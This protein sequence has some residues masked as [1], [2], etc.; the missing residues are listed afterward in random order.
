MAD[1][2]V[3][4]VREILK[5]SPEER[6]ELY[7]VSGQATKNIDKV[8]IDGNVFKDYSAFSFLMEKSYVKSPVRSG[9]GSIPNLDS[10]AWFL[11]P[12]LKIDFSLMS[13][14]SYRAVMNLIRSRSEHTVTCYDVVADKDVTHKM[15]FA[16]E[17]MPK[18]WTI[19]KAL[20]GG[21]EWVE[22]LGV[23]DY[24]IEL[25][26]TN[27]SIDTISVNYVDNLPSGSM[28]SVGES[29]LPKGVEIIVGDLA[30]YKDNP[31]EGFKFKYWNTERDGSGDV[32]LD[33]N[34]I[35]LYDNL[36][37]FAIWEQTGSYTLNYNYG[38]STPMVGSDMKYVYSTP[39]SYGKS[40]GNLPTFEQ[41]P[42][43]T[44]GGDT[45]KK[46]TPYHNGGWYKTPVKG[47]N[48]VPLKDGDLY[49]LSQDGTIYLLYDTIKY[50]IN[51]YLDGTLYTTVTIP[52]GT[53]VPL[54]TLVKSG[55]TFDGWYTDSEY[56]NKFSGA[57][58]PFSLN[59]YAKWVIN[60]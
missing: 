30:T 20:N 2:N 27:T 34:A 4:T 56:K 45:T 55:Y 26:G 36:T 28:S 51:Y 50:N 17:Q 8:T 6:K 35:T 54:P 13:I 60:Q 7:Q 31:P 46:Y 10:Y 43:V 1:K 23:Q 15:Y 3:I 40:I 19:A 32:Y 41:Y 9:D 53:Y 5:K 57:M 48:S 21:N 42:T 47:E 49:W 22:L 37:L 38:L 18:L 16:T 12:H 39:V 44:Y 25:I 33:G 59:L 11:T 58:P 29:G 14:D 24:T 52:Y